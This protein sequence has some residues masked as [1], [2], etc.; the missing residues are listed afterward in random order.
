MKRSY[1]FT[2]LI[3]LFGFHQNLTSQFEKLFLNE[4]DKNI[5]EVICYEIIDNDSSVYS[6]IIYN[7]KG[8]ILSENQP[9]YHIHI[10]YKYDKENRL[11][12]KEALYG[13]SF[14][15][16]TT[17]YKY[18]NNTRIAEINAMGFYSFEIERY[19]DA[20]NIEIKE[21]YFIAAGMGESKVEKQYFYYDKSGKLLKT[22]YLTEY[23]DIKKEAGSLVDI[24]A[25]DELIKELL[26][27]P[28]IRTEQG[29]EIYK[30]N[31]K[32]QLYSRL[33]TNLNTNISIWE[34]IYLINLE[35]LVGFENHYF[36][37]SESMEKNLSSQKYT[38]SFHYNNDK[39]L[40]RVEE[41]TEGIKTTKYYKNNKLIK[42]T[43]SRNQGESITNYHYYYKYY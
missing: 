43:E 14:A 34:K 11:S 6:K 22:M 26:F 30:Y 1:L 3:L 15:N 18:D 12:E 21:I 2:I 4:A 38:K 31:K 5:K 36:L 20:G 16:G 41:N 13:E 7:K 24:K 35:G 29:V 32:G 28:L 42:K 25:K 10:N 19:N 39:E 17:T 9:E 33:Y 8:L 23:L 27:N 40:E 37:N